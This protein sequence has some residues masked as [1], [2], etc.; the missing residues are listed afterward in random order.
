M[1]SNHLPPVEPISDRVVVRRDTADAITKGGIALPAA[2]QGFARLGTVIAVGPGAL[3]VFTGEAAG[4][5]ETRFP[6]QC[7][8]GDRVILPAMCEAIKL[9]PWDDASEVAI[10]QEG[11]LLAILR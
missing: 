3:R 5:R 10:C 6:M 1:S 9:D 7:K 4:T 11:A 2:S 8:V